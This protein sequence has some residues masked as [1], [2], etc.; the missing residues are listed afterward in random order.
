MESD[1][2]IHREGHKEE[3]E[4]EIPQERDP[5]TD[6]NVDTD[7]IMKTQAYKEDLKSFSQSF[8]IKRQLH[9]GRG[10]EFRLQPEQME[11]LAFGRTDHTRIEESSVPSIM[12]PRTMRNEARDT[13]T[14]CEKSHMHKKHLMFTDNT[15]TAK[16][17][18]EEL[19][20][21]VD[22]VEEEKELQVET[23]KPGIFL[24][25]AEVRNMGHYDQT[26]N[27]N[28]DESSQESNMQHNSNSETEEEII[29]QEEPDREIDMII[30]E[31]IT[32]RTLAENRVNREN[33]FQTRAEMQSSVENLS[34]AMPHIQIANEYQQN[35]NT[36]NERRLFNHLMGSGSIDSSDYDDDQNSR[37][38]H[39][40]EEQIESIKVSFLQSLM[41]ERQ[42]ITECKKELKKYKQDFDKRKKQDWDRIHLEKEICKENKKRITKLLKDAEDIIDLDIGGTHA[43]TTT[44]ATLCRFSNSSLAAMFSGRHAMKYNKDRVFIDRDGEPF[45]QLIGYLRTGQLPTISDKKQEYLFKEEMNY[46][47]IPFDLSEE[48]EKCDNQMIPSFDP[49]WCAPTLKLD[50]NQR[51]V[52]KNGANHG[53]IF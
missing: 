41:Q 14:Y 42:K 43:I 10:H 36:I 11:E 45:S 31:R 23:N 12:D 26:F 16:F 49:Q 44:R 48:E 51:V 13:G 7:T 38:P 47:Q 22:E 29:E 34:N 2:D 24:P 19:K 28:D 18:K 6:M 21:E 46:W 5:A 52:K 50:L 8:T 40:L 1:K 27:D 30:D 35:H 3:E 32:P 9:E 20:E 17:P 4:D 33:S 39:G 37:T 25:S 53:I 15:E